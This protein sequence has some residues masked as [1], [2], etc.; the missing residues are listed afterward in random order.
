M[1]NLFSH[2]L[3]SLVI[4]M[5]IVASIPALLPR[6]VVPIVVLEIITGALIGPQALGLVHPHQ[7]TNFLAHFG[8]GLL[9]LMTGFEMD[10]SKLKGEPIRN[11][12]LGWLMSITIAFIIANSLYRFGLTKNI[13]LTATAIS[14]TA[15]SAMLPIL[16][17]SGQLSPPY[18]PY[19]LSAGLMGK[20]GP[21]LFLAV[22]S[23]DRDPF[24]EILLTVFFLAGAIIA[25]FILQKLNGSHLSKIIGKTM[26]TSVQFPMRL[27]MCAL[28]LLVSLSEYLK[29]DTALGAFVAGLL[30]RA[31]IHSD[32]D[33]DI[34][35]RFDGVAS[36]LL[37]PIFFLI[38]GTRLDIPSLIANREAMFMIPVYSVLMLVVR[39]APA[40]L[41]YRSSLNVKQRFR[42]ALHS[43]TQISLVVVITDIGIGK[44][45]ISSMQGAQLVGGSILT[46]LI[47]PIIAEMIF[48]NSEIYTANTDTSYKI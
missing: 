30:L 23:S 9:F 15:I 35:A 11:A 31:I 41:L 20:I 48:R 40:L 3:Q 19:V 10:P 44:G 8:L 39:G 17:D 12:V 13:A 4:A 2:N 18:G 29:I 45:L 5:V 14:T 21:L 28:I 34:S 32:Y 26:H 6:L 27:A 1:D 33:E 16:R 46:I 43:S 38:S 37:I 47:Y 42:L 7:I 36:A 22:I 25:F 24:K